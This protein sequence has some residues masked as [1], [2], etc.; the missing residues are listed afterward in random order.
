[1]D[2]TLRQPWGTLLSPGSTRVPYP[3]GV[4]C[5]YTVELPDGYSDQALSVHFNRFDIAPDDS[6]KGSIR[7][8]AL[9]EGAGFNNDHRPP[10]QLVSRL[11]KAQ[12]VMQSNAVRQAMGF[13]LTYSLSMS[14][15]V[16]SCPPGFEF[17]S[18]R[19]RA[20]D[21]HCQLGGKWTEN[22]LPNCQR[23]YANF[24]IH[25]QHYLYFY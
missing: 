7:G 19:G 12:I 8:K 15:V 18:G 24:F 3:P 6:I 9:H 14:L 13:N 22:A 23:E 17:T 16:V 2:V 25:G 4:Q 11:S 20:F 1:C 21:V 5:T 10:T